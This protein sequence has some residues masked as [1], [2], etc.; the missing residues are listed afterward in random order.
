MTFCPSRAGSWVRRALNLSLWLWGCLAAMKH[1][2]RYPRL[3]DPA[4]VK[5]MVVESVYTT[6]SREDQIVS[7][8]RLRELYEQVERER[9]AASTVG[10][11]AR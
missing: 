4:F 3:R 1:R 8:E 9:A 5:A 11:A 6:M 10:E 7:L 2:D